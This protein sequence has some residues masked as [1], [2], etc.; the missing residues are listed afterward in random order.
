MLT[1]GGGFATA[2]VTQRTVLRER[3]KRILHT[4]ERHNGRGVG[5]DYA[6]TQD[7]IAGVEYQHIGLNDVQHCREGRKVAGTCLGVGDNAASDIRPNVDI[8]RVRL[9]VKTDPR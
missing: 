1:A 6:V 5:I 4:G 7:I 2:R 9:T 3:P 8:V